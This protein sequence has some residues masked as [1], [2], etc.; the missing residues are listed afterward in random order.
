MIRRLRRLTALPLVDLVDEA[1]KAIGL[2]IEVLS[3]PEH[4]AS[5]ARVHLE[6]FAD[7]AAGYATSSDRPSLSGFLSWLEAARAQERGLDV[8][9]VESDTDA[10]QVLTIHAA[11]GLEWDVVAVPPLVEG[12]FPDHT[13]TSVA[14]VRDSVPVEYECSGTPKD[15]GWLIG[16]DSLPYDL[17]GDRDGL[18]R[19]DWRSV[20][21]LKAL[22]V[23]IEDF[24][25]SGGRHA[26][27]EERRLAYVAVTRARTELLLSTHVWGTAKK[28]L[29]VP[30][31]FLLE[32]MDSF[33][34]AVTVEAW[35]PAPDPVDKDGKQVA[36]AEPVPRGAVLGQLAAR[37]A[38]VPTRG[39][40]SH[41]RATAAARG[42]RTGRAGGGLTDG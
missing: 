30:S 32:I 38:R 26:I 34:A 40:W 25:R 19:L 11:K 12:A 22:G 1:E 7:V 2:D 18:P 23:A 29:S 42:S 13:S 3:R 41:A 37:P 14:P 5:T 17:R 24:A 10:V 4:T 9:Q 39:P 6:A 20:P 36:S 35:H 28:T 27:A 16:L 15:K 33:P 8:G 31:R 21:D